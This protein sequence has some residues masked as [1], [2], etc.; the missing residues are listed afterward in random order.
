MILSYNPCLLI[1]T[2][3]NLDFAYISMQTDNTLGLSD[4][5]FSKR[6]DKQLAKAAF[7]AKP[8]QILTA[9]DPLIFNSS[10]IAF[11]NSNIALCQKGQGNKL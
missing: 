9:K 2:I 4:E 3:E 7:T 11:A 8:K 10:I 6:K 5:S 1:A